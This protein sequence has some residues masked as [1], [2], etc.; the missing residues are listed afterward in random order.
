MT[1]APL[2]IK[3]WAVLSF[4]QQ[5]TAEFGYAPT[6]REICRKFRF[7]STKAAVD[8]IRAIKRHGHIVS[9]KNRS[10]TFFPITRVDSQGRRYMAA[11]FRERKPL[12]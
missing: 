8:H 3:Q 9:E 10:R 6:V 5:H 7:A 2:T 1:P 11:A 12:P 4:I